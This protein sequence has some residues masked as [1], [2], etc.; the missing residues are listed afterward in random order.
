M[1]NTNHCNTFFYHL[2]VTN[3]RSY[4]RY[5]IPRLSLK[6]V[7]LWR[8]VSST[9][10]PFILWWWNLET[11][12][13]PLNRSS[14]FIGELRCQ[15]IQMEHALIK[16]SREDPKRSLYCEMS[17]DHIWALPVVD[18]SRY[19]SGDSMSSLLWFWHADNILLSNVERWWI[20]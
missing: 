18:P 4:H 16:Y 10:P 2:S 7:Y 20:L 11:L 19:I 9:A 14:P 15:A 6:V 17:V 8:H 1:H 13:V 12:F 3:I 5:L